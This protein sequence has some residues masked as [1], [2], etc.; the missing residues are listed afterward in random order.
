MPMAGPVCGNRNLCFDREAYEPPVAFS[1]DL[2]GFDLALYR[3]VQFD[4]ERA[5]LGEGQS[6]VLEGPA[7]L[8]VGE[9][10]IA[11]V[12]SEPRKTRMS[13]RAIATA[14]LAT[15]HSCV[16]RFESFVY[17]VKDILQGLAVYVRK[18]RPDL[19]AL[20][21]RG[22]LFGKTDTLTSHAV[23]IPPV[24]Q[25]SVVQLP[26]QIEVVLQQSSL[27]FGGAKDALVG[28]PG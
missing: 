26:A 6:V 3:A 2:H 28:A 17:S 11:V 1:L 22:R 27:P 19:F 16:E 5:N 8:R 9:T 18:V 14:T 13:L 15:L 10:V 12:A 21:Q 4:F 7:E 20:Y 24:L 23:G 25:S